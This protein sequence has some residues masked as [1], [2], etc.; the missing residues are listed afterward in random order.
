M[1]G[2]TSKRGGGCIYLEG[3]TSA[4]HKFGGTYVW[5]DRRLEQH[6]MRYIFL[7]SLTVRGIYD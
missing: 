7:K 2:R 5:R 3:H 1:E 6:M 4:G